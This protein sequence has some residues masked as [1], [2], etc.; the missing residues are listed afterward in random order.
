[1]GTEKNDYVSRRG[2][3]TE[4]VE[5]KICMTTCSPS[6]AYLTSKGFID[7]SGLLKIELD[8]LVKDIG[9]EPNGKTANFFTSESTFGSD[10]VLVVQ[11]K[12]IHVAKKAIPIKAFRCFQGMFES[13]FKEKT[14]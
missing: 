13:G 10:C 9:E 3:I 11:N 8:I 2:Y 12:Q 7:S 14:S 1:M 5:S 6:F 4:N